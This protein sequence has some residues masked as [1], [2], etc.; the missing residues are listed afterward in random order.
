MKK[1]VNSVELVDFMETWLHSKKPMLCGTMSDRKLKRYK[2]YLYKIDS[3]PSDSCIESV[4]ACFFNSGKIVIFKTDHDL[5][6]WHNSLH[7]ELRY[8]PEQECKCKRDDC[9]KNIKSGKC[10][11]PFMIKHVCKKFFKDKYKSRQK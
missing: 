8:K 9:F 3:V 6:Y 1:V 2:K 5:Q 4:E 11:D 7:I 10:T